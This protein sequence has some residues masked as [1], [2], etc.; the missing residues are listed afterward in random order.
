MDLRRRNK[1]IPVKD[2]HIRIKP[3]T[4]ASGHGRYITATPERAL[5]SVGE[6]PLHIY[7]RYKFSPFHFQ[8]SYVTAISILKP[9]CG[10]FRSESGH[11]DPEVVLKNPLK[12]LGGSRYNSFSRRRR[13]AWL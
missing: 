1:T 5:L 11:L 7:N 2:S 6:W 10:V 3:L 12:L 13:R 4:F 9:P 8:N